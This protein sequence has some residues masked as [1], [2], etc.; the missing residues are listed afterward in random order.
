MTTKFL[1]L[2]LTY[3]KKSY[4]SHRATLGLLTT[5]KVE[6]ISSNRR[7]TRSKM[8]YAQGML[9]ILSA[10]LVVWTYVAEEALSAING[11]E[12]PR[13]CRGLMPS[14][15]FPSFPSGNPLSYLLSPAS[16]RVLPHPLT[17]FYLPDLALPYIGLLTLHRTKGFPSIETRQGHP[18][19]QMQLES[20]VSPCVLIGWW[21]SPG[22]LCG[23]WF[24]DIV[25]L[26]I[27]FPKHSAPSVLSLTPPLVS[28][29]CAHSVGWLKTS[30]S[31]LVRYWQNLS[32]DNY[33]RLLSA[34]T[35]W[36]QQ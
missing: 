4:F 18:L 17:H 30:A 29:S 10:L 32:G 23:V 1:K 8:F 33:I 16:M 28:L 11:R 14:I 6:H 5:L 12:G 36:H 2:T 20:W 24:V 31:I 19:L 26:P 34:S 15:L 22:E 13:S 7:P 27:G 3:K 21:F 9:A 35:Y 25:V